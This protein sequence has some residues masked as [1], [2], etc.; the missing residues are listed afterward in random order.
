M[1]KKTFCHTNGITTETEKILWAND[2]NSWED[3][4][5]KYE[6]I[7]FLSQS[8]LNK[9]KTEL[10]LSQE[11]LQTNNL[12][13]FKQKLP[14][15]EHYR[16]KDYG[17]IAFVDI[18]TTGL[19]KY[20]DYIT[21]IGIYD[22]KKPHIYVKG[23]NLEEAKEHLKQFDI[24]VTFNG[25]L[26]DMPFIEYKFNSKYNIVHLDLRFMFK[27]LGLSGGLKNIEKSIGIKRDDEVEDIDGFQAVRL[28]K[29]Y[30]KLGDKEALNLL[31]KYNEEDIVNLKSLLD[32]Y[33]KNKT[34]L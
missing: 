2:I 11:Y 4:F 31:M 19:S 18:E 32:Y 8:Q 27:E 33:I 3:F 24:I 12:N 20:T 14:A 21:L 22:G 34:S 1:L 7:D 13:Y 5:E 10:T 17:K 25:K 16:L 26:F 6:Q 15:K 9:I 30:A 29:K 28:W 23:H